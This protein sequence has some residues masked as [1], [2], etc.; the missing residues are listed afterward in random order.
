MTPGSSQKHKRNQEQPPCFTLHCTSTSQA[1]LG[2]AGPIHLLLL[3]T[4]L[5]YTT[6][7]YDGDAWCT[8]RREMMRDQRSP[9]GTLPVLQHAVGHSPVVYVSQTTAIMRY[10][11]RLF[12]QYTPTLP[13]S[14]LHHLD[15]CLEV[16]VDW[17]NAWTRYT[18]PKIPPTLLDDDIHAFCM[19]LRREY[20]CEVIPRYLHAIHTFLQYFTPSS[21]HAIHFIDI[22]VTC[23]VLDSGMDP[24]LALLKPFPRILGSMQRVLTRPKIQQFLQKQVV[25]QH[26]SALFASPSPFIYDALENTSLDQPA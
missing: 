15:A 7:S 21:S 9:L 22:M 20:Q 1:Y 3:D 10:L 12:P 24:S 16:L 6:T 17:R 11:T 5:P 8:I 26:Y 13:A 23:L 14:S 19:A 2:H 25:M 18:C 4:H